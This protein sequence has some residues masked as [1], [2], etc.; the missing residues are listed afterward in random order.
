MNT[1]LSQAGQP[2]AADDVSAPQTADPVLAFKRAEALESAGRDGEAEQ[3]YRSLLR[4]FPTHA[5]VLNNL[6]L[7]VQRRGDLIEAESLLRRAVSSEPQ[8][9]FFQNS[10]GGVLRAAGKLPEAEV[11]HRRAVDLRPDFIDAHYNL[12]LVL[13]E[14]GQLNEAIAAHRAAVS[15]QPAFAAAMTR[16]GAILNGQG[17]LDD[18][19]TQLDQ[20]LVV[21]PDF[22]DAHYYRGWV[23][24]SLRRFDE[25]LDALARAAT[26]RPGSFEVALATA[27]A[28]RDAGRIDQAL[29]A[30][31]QV[32]EK[33]PERLATH[34]EINQLAWMAGR[35]DLHLRS[36]AHA[37]EHL[38]DDPDL[39]QLEAA[40]RVR[41]SEYAEA[42]QLLRRANALGPERG[43]IVGLL[44]R[45]VAMQ[46]RFE[47]SY[48]L[49]FAAI[50]AEPDVMLHRQEFGFAL[51]RDH[52]P[53][54]ALRI[55]EQARVG[56]PFDQLLLA[57]LAL[58]YR[59][60]G[61]SRYGQLV[62]YDKYVRF[63]DIKAPEGYADSAAFN[64]A[65]ALEL[66]ALH[67]FK[68][69]PIDQT[70]RGGT[71]TTGSLFAEQSTC[72]ARVRETIGLAVSDYIANL[73]DDPEHPMS[74]QKS[75]AFGF[76]GSW[77]CR[78]GPGGH[79]GNHVHPQGWISSAY[80]VRLPDA[81]ADANSRDGWLKLGESNHGLGERDQPECFVK[82]IVGRLV[83]FPSFY[84]HGT[85]P[86]TEGGDRL[87]VAFDVL[88]R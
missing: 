78:L 40:F 87:G 20:A 46:G 79:H 88:P 33:R 26:L 47:E 1:P 65:L 30:Y 3:I 45:S 71:Q 59:E 68:F 62:D 60:L 52:R 31:W 32:L 54:D 29:A 82:P 39:M 77:S 15:Q 10:L 41:R 28:L 81:P 72:I 73:P 35:K 13:E 19:L 4:A 85:V 16:I 69:E 7:V 58:V 84:W 8:E 37:R 9:G 57:G 14:L 38:G 63:Y 22:F 5:A 49:F 12:G 6:A 44:A 55:F 67:T 86:F 11:A 21:A 64:R 2:G 61:D 50:S 56:N 23:L 51:L 24:S 17:A 18:A 53:Q 36:F 34:I 75:A 43:D 27:N 48:P 25:G 83:L 74:Q 70:L 80:Y 42:E 76:V 66:D